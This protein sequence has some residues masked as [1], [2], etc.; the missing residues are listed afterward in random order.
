MADYIILGIIAGVFFIC[1]LGIL[2]SLFR[3]LWSDD[4]E[5]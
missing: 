1:I 2:Q 5:E 4:F 3:A